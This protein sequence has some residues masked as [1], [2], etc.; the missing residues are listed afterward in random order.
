[1][2]QKHMAMH[3]VCT[4][5]SNTIHL[6]GYYSSKY[7]GVRYRSTYKLLVMMHEI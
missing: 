6:G 7:V 4:C 3:T 5:I 2:C 1:M